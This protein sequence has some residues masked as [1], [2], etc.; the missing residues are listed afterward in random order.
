MRQAEP[1][2]IGYKE[3]PEDLDIRIRAHRDYADFRLEDWFASNLKIGTGAALAEIG[4]GNGNWFGTWNQLIG[5]SGFL[6]GIDKNKDLLR[7][8]ADR[9]LSC[10]KFLLNL[11][12]ND[13]SA[14]YDT[15]FDAIICPYSIYYAENARTCVADLHRLLG[16]NGR[17]YLI[18]PT[19]NNAKELYELNKLIFG[20]EAEDR[21]L[22]RA[23]RLETEFLPISKEIFAS[24]SHRVIKRGLSFPSPEA[25]IQYYQAT[26]LFDESC[27]KANRVPTIE[28]ML[29]TQWSGRR[30]SKDVIVIE[31]TC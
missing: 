19:S 10:K 31:A 11:D 25:F 4:C 24:V 23:G 13:L 3:N 6:L 26:L 5:P 20:F 30:L 27:L 15:G 29:A 16:R 9:T 1:S 12:I 2:G 17:L 18:G 22:L 8:A 28:N 7:I 14:I 21:S